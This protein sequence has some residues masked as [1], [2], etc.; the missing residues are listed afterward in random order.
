MLRT[1]LRPRFLGL[2]ALMLAAAAVCAVLANWQWERAHRALT[3]EASG[4]AQL[5]D[6]RE[7]TPV[8][9]AVTNEVAGGIVTARG[10]FEP[11]EQVLVH[12]RA[13][14]GQPAAVV[15]TALHVP[16]AD[17][18]VARL[19]VARGWLPESALRGADGKLDPS[20]APAAPRGEVE[21]RGRIE[22]SEAATGGVR[23]GVAPEIATPMLVNAWGRP[24]YSGYVAQTGGDGQG[25]GAGALRP[26]PESGSDFTR[27]MNLQNLGYALQWVLF[28]AFFLY[29]WW[30][31]VRQ[32]HRD[33]LDERR[34]RL[35]ALAGASE[36]PAASVAPTV[37][38][39]PESSEE[40]HP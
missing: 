20:L 39:A 33:E 5:G 37:P 23:D 25:T 26:L 31:V 3:G 13:V 28:A 38:S 9:G 2:L 7:V 14:D 17:G 18:T 11:S 40:T 21:I 15:V 12:G 24:M 35:L 32:A 8:G 36:S 22:A 6:I 27:G 29:L 1:A 10:R 34:E 16:Q 30:R 19:P 4:P